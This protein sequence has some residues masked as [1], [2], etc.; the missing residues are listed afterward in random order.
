[1][2]QNFVDPIKI[3][4]L[5]RSR[6]NWTGK[7]LIQAIE[8]KFAVRYSNGSAGRFLRTYAPV[9]PSRNFDVARDRINSLIRSRR[10]WTGETLRAAIESNFGVRFSRNYCCRL[11]RGIRGPMK[12][13]F[14]KGSKYTKL[15]GRR[16]RA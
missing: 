15:D 6:R 13:G 16:E 10:Y 7:E 8:R 2:T 11:L 4:K 1:M 12:A 5:I 3:E 14:K 9:Y